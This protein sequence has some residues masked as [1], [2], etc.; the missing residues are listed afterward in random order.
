MVPKYFSQDTEVNVN[1][2]EI[3]ISSEEQKLQER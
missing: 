3:K 2:E 1:V